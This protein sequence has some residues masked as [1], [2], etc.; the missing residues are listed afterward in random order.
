MFTEKDYREFKD[1]IIAETAAI[2]AKKQFRVFIDNFVIAMRKN[3]ISEERIGKII[4][5]FQV[6]VKEK[7]GEEN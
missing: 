3:H 6:I 2:E 1:G 4:D 5:D 7:K